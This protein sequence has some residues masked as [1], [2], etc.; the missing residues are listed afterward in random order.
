MSEQVIIHGLVC[1][2][3]IQ[4]RGQVIMGHGSGGKLSHDLISDIF[5]PPFDNPA[6]RKSNDAAVV[7]VSA[8]ENIAVST[9]SHVVWPIFFP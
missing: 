2:V 9:D 6:L 8:A 7:D 1:P 5:Y 3:P 4:K